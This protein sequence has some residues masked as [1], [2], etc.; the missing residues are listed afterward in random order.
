MNSLE[1]SI[2]PMIDN[3]HFFNF[4]DFQKLKNKYAKYTLCCVFL[5]VTQW[6]PKKKLLIVLANI[7]FKNS[8]LTRCLY[9]DCP[10]LVNLL[11]LRNVQLAPNKHSFWSVIPLMWKMK[12]ALASFP[13]DIHDFWR[14]KIFII[15]GAKGNKVKVYFLR[16]WVTCVS[17][18]TQILHFWSSIYNY[19]LNLNILKLYLDCT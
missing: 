17:L 13:F 19:L 8:F 12:I 5:I 3:W 9:Q 10:I 16:L 15:L 2:V 18:L 1:Y 7:N 14:F 11:L 4:S 6:S